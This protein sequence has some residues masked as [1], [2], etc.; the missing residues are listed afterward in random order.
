MGRVSPRQDPD[1]PRGTNG[2][3]AAATEESGNRLSSGARNILK[4]TGRSASDRAYAAK[5]E[6]RPIRTAE[7]RQRRRMSLAWS[8]PPSASAQWKGSRA[9]P[10]LNARPAR[11][12]WIELNLDRY[13][14][15]PHWAGRAFA[16]SCR[17]GEKR[18][19]V[20]TDNLGRWPPERFDVKARSRPRFG[21]QVTRR[22]ARQE[23]ASQNGPE[24]CRFDRSAC[25]SCDRGGR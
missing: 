21:T 1:A 7:L 25:A 8:S 5:C 12:A 15:F 22:H 3:A 16:E 18:G 14:A 23:E 2:E 13:R 11:L 17:G 24:P 10:P 19:Q 6:N 20:A 4:G 9:G